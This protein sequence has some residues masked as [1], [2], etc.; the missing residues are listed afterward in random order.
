MCADYQKGRLNSLEQVLKKFR[1]LRQIRL[2][3]VAFRSFLQDLQNRFLVHLGDV[4]ELPELEPPRDFL[5]T[6]AKRP[7]KHL[8][9]TELGRSF[10][11]FVEEGAL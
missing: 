3:R 4:E 6:E 11:S 9:V 5:T 1:L 7:R 8:A 10:L 2:E